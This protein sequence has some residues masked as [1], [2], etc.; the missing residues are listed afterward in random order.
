MFSFFKNVAPGDL[1]SVTDANEKLYTYKVVNTEIADA[2]TQQLKI[3]ADLPYLTLITCY[4]FDVLVT[5]N[6][7]FVVTAVLQN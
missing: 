4:P 5:G 3:A 2:S 1:F 6:E 7:R